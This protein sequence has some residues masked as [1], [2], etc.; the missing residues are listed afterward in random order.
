MPAPQMIRRLLFRPR[1]KRPQPVLLWVSSN[2]KMDPLSFGKPFSPP[3]VRKLAICFLN[4]RITEVILPS[5]WRMVILD[6]DLTTL[7]HK[8][9]FVLSRPS[10]RRHIQHLVFRPENVLH[11]LRLAASTSTARTARLSAP[12]SSYSALVTKAF[13]PKF[14]ADH[15]DNPRHASRWMSYGRT[16]LSGWPTG[17]EGWRERRRR[18]SKL[19]TSVLPP[20]TKMFCAE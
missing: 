1:T 8:L 3:D 18:A 17:S 6:G 11:P 2:C 9:D 13:L 7:D 15:F 4:K 12:F 19:G 10:A 20:V 5:W 16:M 14:D